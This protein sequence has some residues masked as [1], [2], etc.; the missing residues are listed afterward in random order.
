MQ[1]PPSPDSDIVLRSTT[2]QEL[3]GAADQ[4]ELALDALAIAVEA[5]IPLQSGGAQQFP[6]ASKEDELA[7]QGFG[8]LQEQAERAIGTLHALARI[9]E[10]GRTDG[11]YS[12]PVALYAFVQPLL[13]ALRDSAQ[14]GNEQRR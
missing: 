13:E 11:E 7:A 2:P 14:P 6:R 12:V 9:A 1:Q 8:E 10:L 4:L 3:R 5:P